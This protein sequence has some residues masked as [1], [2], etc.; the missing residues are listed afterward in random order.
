MRYLFSIYSELI[1]G[2]AM[3]VIADAPYGTRVEIKDEKR[4]L[5]Q[6]A[7]MW[8]LLTDIATQKE[9]CGRHYSTEQWK[10]LMMHACGHEVQFLPA[11]DGKTFVPWANNRSSDLSKAEMSELIEC[12]IAWGTQNGVEFHDREAAA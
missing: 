9:H 12:I 7:K 5:E 10:A 6:N 3:R 4:S 8:A 1:R 2:N 11:L